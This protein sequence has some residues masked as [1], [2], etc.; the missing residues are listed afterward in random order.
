MLINFEIVLTAY[1]P[2]ITTILQLSDDDVT[3]AMISTRLEHVQDNRVC[4]GPV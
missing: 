4:Q 2:V 3:S 1:Q